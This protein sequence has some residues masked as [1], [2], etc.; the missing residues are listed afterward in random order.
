MLLI[1]K[2]RKL[3]VMFF[4]VMPL[5]SLMRDVLGSFM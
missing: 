3:G 1:M 5:W 4:S 2:M